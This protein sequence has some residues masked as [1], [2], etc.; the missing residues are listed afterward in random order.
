M[1]KN[2]NPERMLSAFEASLKI[3]NFKL[4]IS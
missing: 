1:F 4:K 3:K 2:L